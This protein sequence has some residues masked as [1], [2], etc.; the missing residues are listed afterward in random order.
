MVSLLT[1]DTNYDYK[2]ASQATVMTWPVQCSV[3][4]LLLAGV[5]GEK[6]TTC[7]ISCCLACTP[8][9]NCQV[10]YQLNKW[11]PLTCPCVGSLTGGDVS[12]LGTFHRLAS[13]G[14][15]QLEETRT[16]QENTV[17]YR[18]E[19]RL[20][21]QR[22]TCRPLCCPTLSCTTRTCPNCY[23]RHQQQPTVCPCLAL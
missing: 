11:D 6:E 12:L 2:A 5:S 19:Y 22:E 8:G 21:Q 7:M 4:A 18:L 20:S 15:V 13:S 14:S 9:T 1:T 10:C 23:R 17:E 3:L 16:G